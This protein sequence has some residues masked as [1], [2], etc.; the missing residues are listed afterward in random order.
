[1]LSGNSR[2]LATRQPARNFVES[3]PLQTAARG[4]Q[5]SFAKGSYAEI[6]I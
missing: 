6:Q 4:H 1:M 3:R 5:E 2:V